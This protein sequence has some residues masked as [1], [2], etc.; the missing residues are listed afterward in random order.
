MSFSYLYTAAMVVRYFIVD[1]AAHRS[2]SS[3]GSVYAFVTDW[4]S[5]W[6]SMTEAETMCPR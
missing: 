3:C 2:S 5:W 1:N 4:D 6:S